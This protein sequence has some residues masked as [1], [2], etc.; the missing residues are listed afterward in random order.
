LRS[1]SS[2]F[3]L[4]FKAL[5]GQSIQ[6]ALTANFNGKAASTA[7][8]RAKHPVKPSAQKHFTFPNFGFMAYTCHPGPAKGAFAIVTICGP[9]GGG[10]GGDGAAA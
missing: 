1:G 3:L 8:R 7:A 2:R 9:G 10:R 6:I 4:E 5:R